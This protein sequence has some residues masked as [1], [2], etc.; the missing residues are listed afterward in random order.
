MAEV[1][2]FTVSLEPDLLEEFDRF[3]AE[4]KYATRSEAV[5]QLLRER[6]T[7]AA[8]EAGAEDVTASL[9]LVYDHHRSHLLEKLLELQHQHAER[10]VS[11]MHVHLNHDDCMEIIVLRGQAAA[12]R[13]LA[14][15]LRGL[16]GIHLGQLVMAHAA[17]PTGTHQHT[18][19]S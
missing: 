14:G 17:S 8:V 5:R 3:C 9:V 18:H 2:R 16:K 19:E 7:A 6:L 15:E 13:R 11:S 12:L 1:V 4:E 10:V